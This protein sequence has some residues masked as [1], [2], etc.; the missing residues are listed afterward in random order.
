MAPAAGFTGRVIL[1]HDPAQGTKVVSVQDLE[2]PMARQAMAFG[3]AD[4]AAFLSRVRARATAKAR[5]VI[6]QAMTEA[7]DIRRK[8]YAEGHEQGVSAGM[9]EI[10]A[11]GEAIAQR[12]EALLETLRGQGREL[13]KRQAKDLTQ[14]VRLAVERTLRCELNEKR[15]EVLESLL[16]QALDIVDSKRRLTIKVHPDDRPLVEPLMEQARANRPSIG[17]WRLTSSPDLALGGLILES[18]DGLVDNSVETR[19]AEVENV[20]N[21]LSLL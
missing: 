9:A 3:E 2:G 16:S 19:F 8:A 11:Q 15:A 18:D 17:D 20:L 7:E 6:A 14:L 1:P 10:S 21:Q 5:E 12:L 13:L 4:A